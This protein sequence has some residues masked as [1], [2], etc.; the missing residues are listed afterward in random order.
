MERR[1][2]NI[3]DYGAKSGQGTDCTIPVQKALEDIRGM[4]E[5]V[6]L[7]FPKG[8]YHFHKEYALSRTFHTSNTN[9]LDYPEKKIGFLMEEQENLCID[10]DGSLFVFHGNMMAFAAVFCKGIELKN[11]AWDFPC[12]TVSEMLVENVEGNR[13]TYQIPKAQSFEIK[14]KDVNWFEISP[15]SGETYW[16]FKNQ[17]KVAALVLYRPGS[18]TAVRCEEEIWPLWKVEK[19]KELTGHRIEVTY[20]E[21]EARSYEAGMCFEICRND[22]RETAGA[23]FWESEDICV[24]EVKVHYLHSFGWLTQMCRKVSFYQCRFVPRDN[25]G[26]KAAGFADLIHVSGAAGEIRIEECEFGNS[27]DDAINIH[28][29]FTRVKEMPE[30]HS[31]V[32]EYVHDQ[33]GGF[34]Q[35]HPGDK[36]IFYARDTLQGVNGEQEYTVDNKGAVMYRDGRCMRVDFLEELPVCLGDRIGTEGKYVAENVTYTPSVLIKKCRFETIPTRGILCT[37]REKILIEENE[38]HSMS[39]ASIFVS[40][41]SDEWYESG[42]VRDMEIRNNI[43]HVGNPYGFT[44][45]NTAISIHPVVKGEVLPGEDYP[46]H[47]NIRI[48][49]N[50]FHIKNDKVLDAKNVENLSFYE[51]TIFRESDSLEDALKVITLSDCKNAGVYHNNFDDKKVSIPDAI[52]NKQ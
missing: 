25:T 39:M 7:F 3:L 52:I 28:G 30:N 42:P 4:K 1:I 15:L 26:R 41:D 14:G 5:A 6:T 50:T 24:R 43:F 51:N 47:K 22:Y 21:S 31:L 33:Q 10:G 37:T 12:A 36:V 29:T 45:G 17:E 11:F 19:V 16:S 34:P 27:H 48:H 9:S 8:E 20:K 38:F 2:I 40:N 18:K 44:E 35:F 23:F 13:V 49:H 46:V 32:L